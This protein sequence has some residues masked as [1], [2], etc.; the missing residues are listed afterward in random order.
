MGYLGF[1]TDGLSQEMAGPVGSR[2]DSDIPQVLPFQRLPPLVCCH[3]RLRFL[4]HRNT[5]EWKVMSQVTALS[6]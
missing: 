4:S 1:G 5:E 6:L 3:C 2:G